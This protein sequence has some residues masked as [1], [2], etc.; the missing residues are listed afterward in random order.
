[1]IAYGTLK[2]TQSDDYNPLAVI[3]SDWKYKMFDSQVVQ[4]LASD[5]ED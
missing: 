3:S 5:S 4:Q 1:M 2:E